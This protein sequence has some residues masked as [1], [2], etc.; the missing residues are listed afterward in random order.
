MRM[1]NY[2]QSLAM[3][4]FKMADEVSKNK[5]VQISWTKDPSVHQTLKFLA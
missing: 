2:Q 5:K 3:P 1:K 4:V